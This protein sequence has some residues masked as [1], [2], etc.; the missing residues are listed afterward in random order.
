VEI[1]KTLLVLNSNEN[2]TVEMSGVILPPP[3]ICGG[4]NC[5]VKT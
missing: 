4:T 2:G 5:T 3:A 1:E